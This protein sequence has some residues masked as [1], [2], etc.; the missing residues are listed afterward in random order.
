MEAAETAS[1]TIN[2]ID[3]TIIIN[4]DGSIKLHEREH[5]YGS[6]MNIQE[7][8]VDDDDDDERMLMQTLDLMILD[9]EEKDLMERLDRDI[10]RAEQR[11]ER[12]A[13]VMDRTCVLRDIGYNNYDDGNDDD[14]NN[15]STNG[16]NNNGEHPQ[17]L[18][19]LTQLPV[20]WTLYYDENGNDENIM[21][22]Q[23]ELN[24]LESLGHCYPATRK[25]KRWETQ[26]APVLESVKRLTCNLP[27]ATLKLFQ[28]TDLRDSVL[29]MLCNELSK[30]DPDFS[31]RIL[32]SPI[33]PDDNKTNNANF[34]LYVRG[35]D[36]SVQRCHQDVQA[37]IRQRYENFV[38]HLPVPVDLEIELDS[39]RPVGANLKLQSGSEYL[40]ISLHGT[41]GQ[42]ERAVGKNA[43][44]NGAYVL[45]IAGQRCSTIDHF[46]A[47]LQE[48]MGRP[49]RLRL[50][51]NAFSD[52][53]ALNNENLRNISYVDASS[54]Y[55]GNGKGSGVM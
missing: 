30:R 22:H 11:E 44:L 6:V 23:Q 48:Q 49:Y 43:L 9:S 37:W 54:E 33:I 13:L 3:N 7:N 19:P 45:T 26:P 4:T 28:P 39:S 10:H 5:S 51:L 24:S 41:D 27:G 34:V 21:L 16:N 35:T 40:M 12:W 18:L 53:S 38:Q 50:R 20:A 52:L 29:Q 1:G 36:D 32:D 14:D 25:Y 15:N 46:R 47:I 42:L 31:F 2:V 8:A 17:L 55:E